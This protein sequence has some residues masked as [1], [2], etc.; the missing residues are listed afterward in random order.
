MV[1]CS[2]TWYYHGT[3]RY[4]EIFI[5]TNITKH[6][7]SC[8]KVTC[9]PLDRGQK[10]TRCINL[11]KLLGIFTVTQIKIALQTRLHFLISSPP[12]QAAPPAERKYTFTLVLSPCAFVSRWN[13]PCDGETSHAAGAQLKDTH[14]RAASRRRASSRHHPRA[15]KSAAAKDRLKNN[16]DICALF[17]PMFDCMGRIVPKISA[18]LVMVRMRI[19]DGQL[20]TRPP[21]DST[22]RLKGEETLINTSDRKQTTLSL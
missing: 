5:R 6:C 22:K 16:V 18:N 17:R 19:T 21:C 2:K 11:R 14:A 1:S 13:R 9:R 4:F 20:E 8:G 15:T 7:L 3:L 10:S 12:L